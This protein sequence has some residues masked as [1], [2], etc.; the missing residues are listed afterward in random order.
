M[1]FF[2]LLD[3]AFCVVWNW[4]YQMHISVT[5]SPVQHQIAIITI[6]GSQRGKAAVWEGIWAL[7]VE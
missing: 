5:D 3:S 4:G 1:A 2:L 6:H 7:G